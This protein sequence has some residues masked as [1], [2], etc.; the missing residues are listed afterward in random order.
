M[1]K[2]NLSSFPSLGIPKIQIA[3]QECRMESVFSEKGKG[4]NV[5]EIFVII[6]ISQID[7]INVPQSVFLPE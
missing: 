7:V 3:W 1:Q 5:E 2:Q 6:K 4:K